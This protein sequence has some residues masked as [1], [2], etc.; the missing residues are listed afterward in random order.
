MI[1]VRLKR[2]IMYFYIFYNFTPFDVSAIIP[3]GHWETK[4]ISTPL[5]AGLPFTETSHNSATS[6]SEYVQVS[7]ESVL[8]I[9]LM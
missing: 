8:D 7:V 6:F 5:K 1:L 4:R 3:V 2:L 9:P